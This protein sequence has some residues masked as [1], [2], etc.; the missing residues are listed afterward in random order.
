MEWLK[1]P[2]L[3][4]AWEKAGDVFF[5]PT[6]FFFLFSSVSRS[7]CQVISVFIALYDGWFDGYE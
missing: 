2:S 7:V 6:F 3:P 4:G 1:I 5:S